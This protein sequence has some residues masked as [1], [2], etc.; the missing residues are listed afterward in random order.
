MRFPQHER[1]GRRDGI[2]VFEAEARILGERRVVDLERSLAVVQMLQRR[3][4]LAGR[5]VVEHRVPVRERSPLRV[6]A[7]QANRDPLDDQR[8]E[9][10]R[11]GLSPV[12]SSVLERVPATS[13]LRAEL[14][15]HR[16]SL[17]HA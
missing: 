9:G 2:A 4:R 10:E 12:D 13:Q 15:M 3:V 17:G 5:D 16:E 7:G 1:F 8:S 6:L 14:R 11:L